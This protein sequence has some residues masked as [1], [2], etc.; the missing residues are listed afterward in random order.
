MQELIQGTFH[1]HSTYSHDG[2]NTLREVAHALRERGFSFCVMTEHFEDFDEAKFDRYIAEL[3]SVTESTGFIFV[4]G[5][6]VDLEGLHTIVFPVREYTEVV[7]FASRQEIARP[8]FKVLAHPSKYPFERVKTHLERYGIDAVELWNQQADGS[9]IPPIDF[10]R[11]LQSI[12]LR[13]NYRYFFGCDLHSINLTV[14]NVLCLRTPGI[15]TADEIASV[16]ITGDFVARNLATGIEYRNGLD[17][18]EF[19]GWLNALSERSYYR[20]RL[21]RGVRYSLKSVYKMLPKDLRRS[22][23][24]VKN[25][26]RNKV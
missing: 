9:Y 1:F 6:E 21:L 16:L 8:L 20:G 24:D 13:A 4:P 25:Y 15:L 23:N 19:D 2:R 17:R 26:V 22:L 5:T 7:R 14:G 12:P 10:L 18:T 11:S 3:E